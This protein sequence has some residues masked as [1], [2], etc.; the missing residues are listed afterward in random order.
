MAVH[1]G[2]DI[3][4]VHDV[5]QTKQAAAMAAAVREV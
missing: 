1:N 5:A 2:A 4:R 3:V